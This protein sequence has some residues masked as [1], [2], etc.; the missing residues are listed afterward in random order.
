MREINHIKISTD[1]L[2]VTPLA[3]IVHKK[4]N[5]KSVRSKAKSPKKFKKNFDG[6]GFYR[7]FFMQFWVL[8][9][10]F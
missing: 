8:K 4:E 6:F 7:K 9:L 3:R 2:L 5:N 1:N 10:R